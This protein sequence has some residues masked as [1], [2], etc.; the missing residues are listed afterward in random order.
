MDEDVKKY[1]V[2]PDISFE[3]LSLTYDKTTGSI[4]FR[5]YVIMR[6]CEASNFDAAVVEADS[7]DGKGR[8]QI[9]G[10]SGR[11]MLKFVKN[12]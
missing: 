4:S 9:G 3:D 7:P 8:I 5:T 6:I 1:N 10:C 11:L 2:P 12:G